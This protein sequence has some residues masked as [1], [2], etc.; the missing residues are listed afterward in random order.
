MEHPVELGLLGACGVAAAEVV[1]LGNSL[2]APA[3]F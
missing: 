3:L 1:D 2:T